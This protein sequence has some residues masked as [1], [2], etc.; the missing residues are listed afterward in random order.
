[1]QIRYK[2]TVGPLLSG[3]HPRDFENW[4]LNRGWPF[5]R[6]IE[7]CSL[8]TLKQFGTL[9]NGRLMEGSRFLVFDRAFN[10]I[11][12]FSHMKFAYQC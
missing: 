12:L 5:N 1:M 3:H 4:P 2:N 9:K 7:Y 11:Q 10:D 8:E 6:G